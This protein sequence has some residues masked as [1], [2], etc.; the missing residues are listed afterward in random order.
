MAVLPWVHW[1]VFPERRRLRSVA[2]V[3]PEEPGGFGTPEGMIQRRRRRLAP[4]HLQ[5]T[6]K[7]EPSDAGAQ[8][9]GFRVDPRGP[10]SLRNSDGDMR[11]LVHPCWTFFSSF[12]FCPF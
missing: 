7:N 2:P 11:I 3:T 1:F 6:R 5:A 10:R 4:T 12:S 8:H 9:R